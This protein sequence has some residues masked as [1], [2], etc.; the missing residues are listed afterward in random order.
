MSNRLLVVVGPTASGKSGLALKL[1]QQFNGEIIAAD[2]R[3]IYRGMDIGTAKPTAAERKAVPHHLI[4]I[5]DPDQPFSAADFQQQANQAIA[6]IQARGRLPIMV[7]GTGL[8]VDSVIYNYSFKPGE[9][10][11]HDSALAALSLEELQIRAEELGI[12]LNHSDWHNPRRLIRA[13]ETNG[14]PPTKHE[15][16]PDT[17]M[18]GLSVDPAELEARI[19]TR[20]HQMVQHGFQQEVEE[21][22]RHHKPDSEA[23][24]GIGYGSFA[25]LAAGSLTQQQAIDQT[26]Q[27]TKRYAKRQLTWF[28]RNTDIRW[29]HNA[30]EAEVLVSEFLA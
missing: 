4:D 25:R 20:V 9:A 17:L 14:Q 12:S 11:Q 18:L 23:M 19:A 8:Y 2:S 28:K 6:D 15:L 24:T 13:I 21:L 10:A 29:V 26:I 30:T 1:A 27:D 5:V 22:L 7:G 16:R 3:T